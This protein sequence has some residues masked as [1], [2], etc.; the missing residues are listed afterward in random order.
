MTKLKRSGW[1]IHIVL[2]MLCLGPGR[3]AAELPL[4]SIPSK[5]R[6]DF[7][8]SLLA[9]TREV[10][11][12]TH[13]P[14]PCTRPTDGLALEA[15]RGFKNNAFSF[16]AAYR[17]QLT[18]PKHASEPRGFNA[19]TQLG[20]HVH[21]AT[22]RS[23]EAGVGPAMGFSISRA[24]AE[25]PWRGYLEGFLGVQGA[26]V[27][28]PASSRIEVPVRASVG[29]QG[30]VGDVHLMLMARGGWDDIHLDRGQRTALDAT[31]AVGL[32]HFE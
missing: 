1:A 22:P 20:L 10:G 14:F 2:L 8:T 5:G 26:S 16:D 29:V 9:G 6:H 19:S 23:A 13:V 24:T 12:G 18:R 17:L 4:L 31:L 21:T 28:S 32:L 7:Q 3:A 11:L 27:I 15:R 30:K 25:V